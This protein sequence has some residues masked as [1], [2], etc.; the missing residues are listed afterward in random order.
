MDSETLPVASSPKHMD[1][2]EASSRRIPGEGETQEAIQ[3]VP[4][5][6]TPVAEHMGKN[7]HGC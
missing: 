7:P 6:E 1:E 4:Q 5:G 3:E 2:A